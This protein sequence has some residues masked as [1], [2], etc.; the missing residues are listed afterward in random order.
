[1]GIEEHMI[2]AQLSVADQM[3]MGTV[4]SEV[5]SEICFLPSVRQDCLGNLQMYSD[6]FRPDR[7]TVRTIPHTPA[8]EDVCQTMIEEWVGW[9]SFC[10]QY[11][12]TETT[13]N[14]NLLLILHVEVPDDE[15][16]ENRKGEVGGDKPC[17]NKLGLAF[18]EAI[19]GNASQHSHPTV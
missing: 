3:S 15:P 13:G 19:R 2:V 6:A 11:S 7:A 14:G 16:W 5:Q 10:L 9:V 12:K 17:W 4:S 18:V 8:L 1:M